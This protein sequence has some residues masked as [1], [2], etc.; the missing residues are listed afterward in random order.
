MYRTCGSEFCELRSQ[1][2]KLKALFIVLISLIAGPAWA[3]TCDSVSVSGPVG[4]V[5]GSWVLDGKLTGAAVELAQTTLKAAGVKNIKFVTYKSWAEVL[6]AARSGELDM[7]ISAGWSVERSRY[8]SFVYPAY[9]YQF[10]YVMVRKGET[11]PI[12]K[13][14]D[15][16]GRKGITG[17]SI[18]FGDSAFG[19]FVESQLELARAP[20]IGES[21]KRLFNRE[22][23]YILAY[24]DAARAEVYVRDL[25]D[26]VQVLSTYPFRIDTFFAFSKRSKCASVLADRLGAEVIK[27]AKTNQYF[28]FSKKYRTIFNESQNISP[29]PAATPPAK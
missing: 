5:P 26:K 25:G 12:T 13:Y 27:A 15:L 23:D 7:I 8:L 6:A 28:L 16:K 4:D 22:V 29:A 18:T 20:N 17:A 9:G 2:K 24:A 10:L 11:F 14:E 1:M 21:F 3:Q 19:L